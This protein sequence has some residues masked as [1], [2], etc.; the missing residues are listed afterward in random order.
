MQSLIDD[1][2]NFDEKQAKKNE[3]IK[4]SK[5]DFNQVFNDNLSDSLDSVNSVNS[6]KS[7]K[8][9]SEASSIRVIS[10]S[11]SDF[12]NDSSENYFSNQNESEIENANDKRGS[13]FYFLKLRNNGENTCYANSAIQMLLSCGSRLFDIVKSKECES[14]FCETFKQFIAFFERKESRVVSSKSLRNVAHITNNEINDCYLNQSQQDSFSFLL[15]LL[16]ISCREV[17][18][19]FKINY[20]N[21]NVCNQC[22]NVL[23]FEKIHATYFISLT[24]SKDEEIDFENLFS[25]TIHELDCLKC[26]CKTQSSKNIYCVTGN[27]LMIR[28]VLNNSIDERLKTKIN[29]DLNVPILIPGV[30]GVF[31]CKSAIIHY[32]TSQ[33]SGHYTCY[34]RI[35][36]N[37]HFNW[38]EIS[39]SSF[40]KKFSLPE[41]LKNVYL[42]MLEKISL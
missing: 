30:E 2:I 39:D 27:F 14:K 33:K 34:S 3:P 32:G 38:L 22:T 17:K 40:K 9:S 11:S 18:R 36:D 10:S 29:V 13:Q 1:E 24:R 20:T 35:K 26:G 4:Q 37:I 8:E 31:E 19:C 12:S 28:M 25:P 15:H 42:I 6:H 16:F 41:D 23:N 5:I 7:G 21:S